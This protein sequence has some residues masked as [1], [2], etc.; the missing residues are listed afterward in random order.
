L[1]ANQ[2]CRAALGRFAVSR[3]L[4]MDAW[5]RSWKNTTEAASVGV[6]AGAY[7]ESVRDFYLHH[8]FISCWTI[9]KNSSSRWGRSK[10]RSGDSLAAADADK[11]VADPLGLCLGPSI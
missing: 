1:L 4:L 9:R 3:I 10:K 11:T 5:F 6:V 7:N 2:R 8:E